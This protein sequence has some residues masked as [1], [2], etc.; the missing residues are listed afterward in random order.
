MED[1]VIT[2]LENNIDEYEKLLEII[3]SEISIKEVELAVKKKR[4][5]CSVD[6]IAPDFSTT[7]IIRGHYEINEWDI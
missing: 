1:P 4:K 3:D 7:I 2:D 5:G 6:S